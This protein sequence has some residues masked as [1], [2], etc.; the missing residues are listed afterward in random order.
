M[1][2]WKEEYCVGVEF[3][4]EQHKELVVI[5]NKIYELL[6]NDLIADKY[7]SI[8]AIIDELKDYTVYHFKAEEEYM[9]S[10]GYKK[11]LSQKVAHNDFLEKMQSIDMDKIDNGHNEYLIEMLDFVCE[12]LVQHIVKEDKLITAQ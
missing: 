1:I 10:I 3:I 9:K 6:K 5:A 12:W 7:D 2:L 11:L 8:I 4:D